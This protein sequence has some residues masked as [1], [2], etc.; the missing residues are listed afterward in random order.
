LVQWFKMGHI[1]IVVLEQEG[2]GV[3]VPRNWLEV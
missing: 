3:N 2:K 1:L